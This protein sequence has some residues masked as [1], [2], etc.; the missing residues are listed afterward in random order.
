VCSTAHPG[1]HSPL[2]AA[3]RPLP[4]TVDEPLDDDAAAA[5]LEQQSLL[6]SSPSPSSSSSTLRLSSAAEPSSS[7][8]GDGGPWSLWCNYGDPC[9][10]ICAGMTW[11]LL[12]WPAYVLWTRVLLPWE[13]LWAD[14]LWAPG[15]MIVYVLLA[16]LAIVSHCKA[17]MTDP[18]S[19]PYGCLPLTPPPESGLYPSCAHCAYGYKPPR[20]HHCSICKRCISKMDH[21]CPSV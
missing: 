5:D 1:A 7:S 9:G 19:I 6:A 10:L 14:G 11:F 13:S 8:G 15:C 4:P 2:S 20:A 21:H 17:M 18:G 16:G 12:I 3:S